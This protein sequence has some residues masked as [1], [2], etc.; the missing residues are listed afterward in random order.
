[1]AAGSD[2]PLEA[3]SLE[4]PDE[5]GETEWLEVAFEPDP[6]PLPPPAKLPMMPRTMKKPK[7]PKHPMTNGFRFF[8]GGG[9][10]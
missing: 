5:E 7:I 6:E 2:E 4:E 10:G 9:T 8:F 1:M 3:E